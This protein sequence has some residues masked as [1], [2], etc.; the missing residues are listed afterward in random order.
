MPKIITELDVLLEHHSVPVRAVTDQRDLAK[1]EV[2]PFRDESAPHLRA[3]FLAW[4]ALVRQQL[5]SGT[6]EQFNTADCVEVVNIDTDDQEDE[7]GL[8]PGRTAT[9]G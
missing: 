5:Y 2:Q 1:W 7:Q 3:R 6:F 9:P 4:S 8:D